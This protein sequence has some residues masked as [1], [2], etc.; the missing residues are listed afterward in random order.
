MVVALRMA[1]QHRSVALLVD[2]AAALQRLAW[3][4]SQDFRPSPRRI[5]DFDVMQDLVS[6]LIHRQENGFTTTFVKVHGHSGDPLHAIADHLAVQGAGQEEEEAEYVNGRPD[7]ILYSWKWHGENKVHPWGPQIKNHIKHVTGR[8]DSEEH[9]GQGVVS[10]F[11]GR[12]DAGRALLGSALR[13]TWDWAVRGWMMGV[14]PHSYPVQANI[15]K[16]QKKGTAGCACGQS[17][18]TFAHLQFTCSLEHRRS[19]RQQAHN[20]IAKLVERHAEQIAP[21]D[22]IAVWD[23][24]VST[25]LVALGEA[26]PNGA[27]L[28]GITLRNLAQWKTSVRRDPTATQLVGTK[29]SLADVNAYFDAEDLKKRPDGLI[30]DLQKRTIYVVEIA[31]TGDSEGSL[32]NRFIQKTVKYGPIVE[33]LRQAFHPCRVEQITLVIGALG[34][35]IESVWRRSLAVLG[36]SDAQQDKLLRHCMTATIEGTHSVLLAKP[37]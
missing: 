31:R 12:A 9:L 29:R 22:R 4:R 1:K 28:N 24:Q 20:K 23:K 30:F 27:V 17:R 2:S 32:R 36:M 14:S 3:C 19:M 26:R 35:V 10:D 37:S 25:F 11:L 15:C 5:K 6:A 34:S 18:E 13:S 21:R 33:A 7:G 16:W 8:Q